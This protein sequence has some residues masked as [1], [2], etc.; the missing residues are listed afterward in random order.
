MGHSLLERNPLASCAIKGHEVKAI[1][2]PD[3]CP[4]DYALVKV[5]LAHFE[6]EA[7]S[8]NPVIGTTEVEQC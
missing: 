5:Q 7:V 2:H 8:P 1:V 3:L 4:P 6:E